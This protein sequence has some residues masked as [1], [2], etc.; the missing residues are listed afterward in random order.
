M[1]ATLLLITGAKAKPQV[2]LNVKD[3]TEA[4]KAWKQNGQDG[5]LVS[6]TGA[7]PADDV[8]QA[9]LQAAGKRRLAANWPWVPSGS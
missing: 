7:L 2:T 6:L 1:A 3:V 8:I 9:R 5:W 4:L